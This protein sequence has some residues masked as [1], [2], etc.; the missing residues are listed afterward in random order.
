MLHQ[1]RVIVTTQNKRFTK[2][3]FLLSLI[4]KSSSSSSKKHLREILHYQRLDWLSV[5]LLFSFT[6]ITV[7]N[8]K[9]DTCSI[10]VIQ[11]IGNCIL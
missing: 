8:L 5:K 4:L 1:L 3:L 9:K 10:I 6:G 2:A 11:Y 7:Q